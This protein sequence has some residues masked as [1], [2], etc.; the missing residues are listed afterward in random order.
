MAQCYNAALCHFSPKLP[1]RVVVN[2]T[3]SLFLAIIG[4]LI[5]VMRAFSITYSHVSH[6]KNR[7]F[8]FKITRRVYDDSFY[9]YSDRY[10]GGYWSLA[11]YAL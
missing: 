10:D 5:A 4:G 6:Q 2:N 11:G 3:S 1:Y 7:K 8:S 9:M